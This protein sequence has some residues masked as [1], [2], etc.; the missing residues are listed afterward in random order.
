[1]REATALREAS[2]SR[3][4]RALGVAWRGAVR[5]GACGGMRDSTKAATLEAVRAPVDAERLQRFMRELGRR[6]RGP[7]R[8]YLTGGATAVLH[9][10]RSSTVDV[11]IKLEPEPPGAFEAIATLKNELDINVELA[12]PDQFLPAPTDWAGRSSFIA[13]FGQI[14][15]RHFD[16]RAQALS[17][18]ARGHGRD[19]ADAEAMIERGLVS[20]EELGRALDEIDDWLVRYPALD[21]DAFRRRARAFLGDDDD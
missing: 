8:V 15:F 18:I 6:V 13:S 21:A 14:E 9:G 20:K 1:M 12:S 16:Y 10:W 3:A 19:L 11:D 7:G 17:K 2:Q 4:V 5:V